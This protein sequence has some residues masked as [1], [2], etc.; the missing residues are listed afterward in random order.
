MELQTVV[1]HGNTVAFRKAGEGP[2]VVLIHGMAGS[3][4][5]WDHILPAL[6]KQATVIAP[7]LPGH[8]IS[9]KPSGD[10]SLGAMASGVR[11]LLVMLGID[12]ATIVGQSLGGGIAMQFAYQFPERC[13]RLVLVSSGGLGREVNGLLRALS[14]PGAEYALAV[15]CAPW[16]RNTGIAVAGWLGRIGFQPRA[17]LSQIWR[18]YSSLGNNEAR[19]AFI[20]TLRAVIDVAGQ[21]VSAADRLYLTTEMPTLIVWGDRDRIIPVAHALTAHSAMPGSRLEIFEGAG[22]YPH[23]DAP[24]RFVEILEDFISTTTPHVFSE[25]ELRGR[26]AAVSGDL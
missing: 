12:R 4:Q 13:E 26:I 9:A 10:Y 3:S 1:I 11:D 19:S 23:H 17:H 16:I 7:D 25:E 14:F 18:S 2:A 5:T 6:A 15:G 24:E 20:Q 22:H 21:R 8:G